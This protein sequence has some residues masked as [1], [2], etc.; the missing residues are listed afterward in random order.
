[1]ARRKAPRTRIQKSGNGHSYYLDGE[2]IKGVTTILGQGIPKPALQGWAAKATAEFV[3]NGLQLREDGSVSADQLMR[4]LRAANADSPAWAQ[5]DLSTDRGLQLLNISQVLAG[6]R[7]RDRDAAGR[8]GSE[9]HDIAEALAQGKSVEVPEEIAGHVDAYVRFLDEWRPSN[10]I[11]ERVVVN[12]EWGYMGKFDLIAEFPD[13]V[14][15]NGPNQGEPLG[16]GLLDIK[17][18][19]SGI[20]PEV[21]LQLEGYAHGESMLA[22][23]DEDPEAEEPLPHIDFVGA[24]HVRADGYDVFTFDRGEDGSGDDVFR[25]FLYA[26]EI[27]DFFDEKNGVAA[28]LKSDSLRPPIAQVAE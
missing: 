28:T 26:K 1:M 25:M 4:D 6:V 3:A 8:R 7:F 10:A 23:T 14:W 13:K 24:I 22:P 20:Y 2:R 16:T 21:A 18:A 9:V 15:A 5:K 19:R 27:G 11:L 12:R 17:T